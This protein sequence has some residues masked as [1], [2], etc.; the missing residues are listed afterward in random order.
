MKKIWYLPV[1]SKDST[2]P[3]QIS[4]W[5]K[6]KC[7]TLSATGEPLLYR[8]LS[9]SP[10]YDSKIIVGYYIIDADLID[11]TSVTASSGR[12]PTTRGFQASEISSYLDLSNNQV[13]TNPFH[14][15][16]NLIPIPMENQERAP[17][18]MR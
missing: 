11:L 6:C 1:F 14:S 5:D 17:G 3:S 12:V 18:L 4:F 9:I 8:Y 16:S 13:I 10:N 2:D 15:E 7:P